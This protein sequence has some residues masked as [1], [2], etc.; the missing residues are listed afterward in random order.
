MSRTGEMIKALLIKGLSQKQI[1]DSLGL[2]LAMV[3]GIADE[4]GVTFDLTPLWLQEWEKDE[5]RG[6]K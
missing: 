5:L 1:A 6:K 4:E 2:P 3:E